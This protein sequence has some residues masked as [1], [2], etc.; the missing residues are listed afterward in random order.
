MSLQSNS[1]FDTDAQ[2]RSCALRTS[3]LCA[4]QVGR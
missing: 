4:G 1:F 3:L 2:L